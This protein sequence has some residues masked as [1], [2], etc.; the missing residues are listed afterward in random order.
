MMKFDW[1]V[2]KDQM[3]T[4]IEFS[5]DDWGH[6]SNFMDDEYRILEKVD[7]LA[8]AE[9]KPTVLLYTRDSMHECPPDELNEQDKEKMRKLLRRLGYKRSEDWTSGKLNK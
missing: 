6:E 4:F 8:P 9:W 2:S 5:L 1:K 7:V 3:G